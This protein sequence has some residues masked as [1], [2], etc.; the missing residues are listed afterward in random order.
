LDIWPLARHLLEQRKSFVGIIIATEVYD[1]LLI[2]IFFSKP[3]Y[4]KSPPAE[5]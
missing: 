3:C 2:A 4:I 5:G 1:V